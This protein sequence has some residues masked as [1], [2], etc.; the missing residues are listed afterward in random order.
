LDNNEIGDDG[1]KYLAD[2]LKEN[3]VSVIFIRNFI[4]LRYL[5][6]RRHSLH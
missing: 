2:V 3:M 5:F 4:Y 6:V 1:V